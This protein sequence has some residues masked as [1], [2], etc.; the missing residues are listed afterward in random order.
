MGMSAG[1]AKALGVLEMLAAA[2]I[3]IGVFAQVG[4]TIIILVMAGAIYKKIVDWKTGFYAEEGFGWHYDTL[5]MICSLV[6]FTTA[7]GQLIL[8]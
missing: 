6:V 1:M 5:I 4:S 3:A 2:S 7:G 8:V